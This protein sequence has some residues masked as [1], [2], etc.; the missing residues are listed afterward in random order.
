MWDWVSGDVKIH[1][2]IDPQLIAWHPDGQTLL[3]VGSNGEVASWN[4][5]T[6]LS[7]RQ[8]VSADRVALM[9]VAVAA[10]GRAAA[11]NRNGDLFIWQ[12]DRDDPP[13]CLA[14]PPKPS[15][16]EYL[17]TSHPLA[18]S[19]DGLSAALTYGDGIVYAGS[20][21]DGEFRP[22][23]THPAGHE[24]TEDGH[25]VILRYT[26]AGRL[27]IAGSF[28]T[29]RDNHWWYGITVTDGLSGEVVWRLPPKPQWESAMALSPDGRLL[30]TG[31][32]DGT[33]LVWPLVAS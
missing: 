11:L 33:L 29:L 1:P 3:A 23:Y 5:E 22:V 12:L 31:H 28:T 32:E 9:G 2:E 20:V 14:V 10:G 8:P 24:E 25:S 13:R 7:R 17:S 16:P 26:S 19:P 15:M 21:A 6:G 18:L 30:L 4:L 27:L